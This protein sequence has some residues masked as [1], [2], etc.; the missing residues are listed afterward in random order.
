MKEGTVT[1][2]VP[3]ARQREAIEAPLGPALVLAGPGAGKTYCLIERIRFLIEQGGFEPAR[4][5]A[6]TF[7]NK[8]AEEISERLSAALGERARR[9][10]RGTLHA[11]CTEILREHGEWVGARRGF[12]IADDDYQREVLRRLRVGDKRRGGV[13]VRFGLHRARGAPLSHDELRLFG[14][15][16]EHL[17]H[18]RLLDFDDLIAKTAELLAGY[19]EIAETVAARWTYLLVDEFQDLNPRQ[20]AV[21]RQLAWAHRNI[22]GVGDDEQSV[23]SWAGADPGVLREFVNDF[24]IR[25]WHLLDENHRTARQIFEPAQRLLRQNP[26]LFEEKMLRAE[27]QSPHRV[28]VVGFP[29]DAAE[30]RWLLTDLAA[31]QAI[32][33][34]SW[35]DYGVLYRTHDIGNV[36]E[37]ALIGAGIPCRLAAG[38]ALQDDPV[39]RYLLATLRVIAQPDDAI[40]QAGYFREVL[41]VPLWA[42]IAS[43]AERR[44]IGLHAC[45][46]GLIRRLGR[47]DQDGKKIR[48]AI[49]A[50]RNLPALATRHHR[51]GH[52]VEELLSQRV[53]EYRTVLED[54]QDDLTDPALDGDVVK[55]AGRLQAALQRRAQV[56]LPRI[57]GLEIGVSGMLASAGV[58]ARIE[59]GEELLPEDVRLGPGDGGRQGFAFGVF[60]ALQLVRTR[61]LE[62]AF[63]DFVAVDIET[64][65]FDSRTCEVIELGAVRVRD[66]NA[67]ERFQRLIRPRSPVTEESRAVH[68]ITDLELEHQ[69]PIEEV[70][71]EFMAFCGADILIAHNGN[72]YDFPILRR[73][74]KDLA[75]GADFVGY[76]SLPLARSLHL[77]SRKL[78]HLAEH[79][80]VSVT[81]SHRALADAETLA[82]VF[83]R[84]QSLKLARARTTALSH[85]LDYLGL[86]LVLSDPASVPPEA[87]GI[88][89]V[90]KAFALGRYSDCLDYY[91]VERARS[92]VENA[93][94]VD[95]VIER[96][97]G[98][99]RMLH[100]RRDRA[101]NERYP[102]A[103]ARLRR[104]LEGAAG[105]SLDAE[106]QRFLDLV[107]LSHSGRDDEGAE[108]LDRVN[109]LTLHSTKGLEFSRV[110]VI[111]VE[112]GQFN[113]VDREGRGPSASELQESRRLLYVG[114]TRARDRLVLTRVEKRQGQPTG[115]TRFLEE[116]GLTTDTP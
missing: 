58:P 36:L 105:E 60:K 104:L 95:E 52:L 70:W 19:G 14:R 9:I 4:I 103:M 22:F 37:A 15:Y 54:R 65:S 111:G 69:P 66:G 68:G 43:E 23:Y 55:L 62:D 47:D 87:S 40:R 20:Y 25:K 109:L 74:G 57:A 97:G 85:L 10:K 27:R 2:F 39:V 67:V 99:R 18:R 71:P 84:L 77:G 1:G 80:G 116:M 12:G 3:S 30:L 107:A 78:A 21:L 112:D 24:G 110:Y 44:K 28:V 38:R 34:L 48:R 42:S 53:G 17:E 29:D 72:G 50:V 49:L 81:E 79:F 83:P 91:R 61:G 93:P 45:M 31:D 8:A 56:V 86:S 63:R 96:L 108:P 64:S 51:L 88:I 94:S 113:R 6:V 5:C 11:L 41:P 115:G 59:G 102:A 101:A 114:M 106:L 90:A 89:E 32:S 35:G 7:T 82:Q 100:I 13:L 98:H 75:G 92:G 73:V 16:R 76:D 33:G 46:R 26:P